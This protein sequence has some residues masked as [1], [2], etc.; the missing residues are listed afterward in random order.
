MAGLL[1]APGRLAGQQMGP[2]PLV[3]RVQGASQRLEMIVNTSRILT[4]DQ[5]IP[6]VGV[7]NKEVLDLTPLSATQVQ[8]LAKKAGVTQVNL[9]DEQEN[10]HVVDVIVFGDAQELSMLLQSQF[11]KASLKVIPLASSV[12]ISGY[13]DDPDQVDRIIKMAEDYHPKVINNIRVGGVQQ[14]LLQVRVME[15]SRTKL[16]RAGVDFAAFSSSGD[17]FVSSISGLIAT[18]SNTAG[19]VTSTGGETASFGILD[20]SNSF[21]AFLE[22]LQQRNLAK[23]L[24]EPQLVTVSGRPAF[25]NSGGE[26]PILVPQSLGTVSVQYRKFGTQVDFVPIVLGNGA[27]RLEVRPRVSEIDPSRSVTINDTSVP[28]LRVREV[29]TGVE[30]RAGQTLAIAGLVQNR[31]EAQVRGVPWVSDLPWVG[32]AF[33]RTSE[34]VNEIELLI[35]V[36]PQLVDALDPH[37]VPPCGPGFDT[38]SPTDIQL[39]MRGHIEVPRCCTDGSCADCRARGGIGADVLPPGAYEVPVE[40]IGPPP[41]PQPGQSGQR[42]KASNVRPTRLPASGNSLR[43]APSGPDETSAG[44]AGSERQHRHKPSSRNRQAPSAQAVGQKTPPGFIGPIGYDV[45]K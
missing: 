6:R 45:V 37:E 13:V 44:P 9:W 15:V 8:I 23:I 40:S 20:S 4:L 18:A 32:A 33:R 19:T 2:N 21:F 17:F 25:F 43:R 16:R 1:A 12:L 10:V 29:D 42:G 30:M 34:E 38:A 5:K 14:V 36:T 26:F 3:H 24:A 28:G 27:I 11:P 7:N 39:Y 22:L 35:M 31:V 41:T